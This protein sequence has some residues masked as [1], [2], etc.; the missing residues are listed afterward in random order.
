MNAFR[1]IAIVGA[2]ESTRRKADGVH[3]FQILQECVA[4]ALQD[5][6]MTLTEVD[7]LCV[8]AGDIAEGGMVEDV[9][10]V[11]EYLGIRPGFVESTD[12]GGISSVSQTAKACAAIAA[13]LAD[14]VVVAY[15][16][17]PRRFPFGADWP[18]VWP[19]GPGAYE[20][21]FGV[22]NAVGY[23][24]YAQR[25]MYE[26]GTTLEQLAE[27]VSVIRANGARNPHA[28]YREAVDPADVLKAPVIASPFTKP[29]CCVVSDSGGAVVITRRDRSRDTPNPP[30]R[31]LGF[32]ETVQQSLMNQVPD[33]TVS[34]GAYSAPRA[35]RTAGLTPADVDVAQLYD[36]FAI[37]PLMALEDLGFCPKGEGGRFI[38]D[39]NV[40]PDGRIPINTDGGGL[41]SNHP[42]KRGIF[43]LIEAI[44]QL[45]GVGPGVQIPDVE[46]SLVHGIGGF[47]SAA[48]T[49]LLARHD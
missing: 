36:A 16:A 11:A 32:G 7:G 40:R 4:G 24:L 42:G 43:A 47:H 14:T 9:I 39:G 22:T 30:I 6:G 17:C 1:D 20:T 28:L 48:A 25:H 8:T 29:M 45:R 12:I 15:A 34:P 49:M 35:F 44:R 19:I 37:T 3:P 21:P 23:A 38:A 10:E 2:F 31:I 5:A 27:L 41:A 13:G 26:Y 33:F 46:V 18:V